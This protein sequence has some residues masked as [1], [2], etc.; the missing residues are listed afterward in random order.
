[1][2][3]GSGQMKEKATREFIISGVQN[4]HGICAL[5]SRVNQ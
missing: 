4:L 5:A 1:M 3:P 2:C